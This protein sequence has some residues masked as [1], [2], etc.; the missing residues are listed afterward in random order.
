VN[1]TEVPAHTLLALSEIVNEALAL[2]R[3][4]MTILF[5]L[6]VEEVTQGALEVIKTHTV[7][8][9]PRELVE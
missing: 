9:S 7:S 4:S 8:L 5:D 2:G 3:S 1:V 6:A